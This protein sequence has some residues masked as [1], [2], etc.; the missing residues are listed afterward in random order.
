VE[1]AIAARVIERLHRFKSGA[2]FDACVEV[3]LG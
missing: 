2:R 1:P 3:R